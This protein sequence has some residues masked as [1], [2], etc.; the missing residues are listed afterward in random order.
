MGGHRQLTEDHHLRTN[1]YIY[2]VL[3]KDLMI[4]EQIKEYQK[5]LGYVSNEQL[6]Q[7][8]RDGRLKLP[9]NSS[10]IY[11]AAKINSPSIAT[12]KGRNNRRKPNLSPVMEHN[13]EK[14]THQTLEIDIMFIHKQAYLV[15][16][17]QPMGLLSVDHMSS[18]PKNTTI[19]RH[20]Q[21]YQWFPRASIHNLRDQK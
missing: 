5:R 15:T 4:A 9:F 11:K 7:I 17:A 1:E 18:S 13:S 21:P 20:L 19:K 12:L 8:A 14:V 3:K 16:L 2:T 6:A 10:D